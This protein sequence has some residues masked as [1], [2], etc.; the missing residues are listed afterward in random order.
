MDE[1]SPKSSLFLIKIVFDIFLALVYPIPNPPL[2]RS[3]LSRIIHFA[4]E[5]AEHG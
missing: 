1:V 2:P 4:K 5:P 3:Y